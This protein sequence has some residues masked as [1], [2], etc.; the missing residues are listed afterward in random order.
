MNYDLIS[1]E[2]FYPRLPEIGKYQTDQESDFSQRLSRLAWWLI[3]A[4]GQVLHI[5]S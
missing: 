5:P 4:G 3:K 2:A 1:H